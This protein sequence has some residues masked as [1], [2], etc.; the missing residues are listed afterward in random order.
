MGEHEGALD[1]S[2]S[3]IETQ[4]AEIERMREHL[5]G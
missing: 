1:L 5:A 4:A 3:I 2:A